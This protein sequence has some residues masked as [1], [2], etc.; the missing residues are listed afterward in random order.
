MVLDKI[1]I[2]SSLILQLFWRM[3]LNPGKVLQAYCIIMFIH[4]NRLSGQIKTFITY[5]PHTIHIDEDDEKTLLDFAKFCGK[6]DVSEITPLDV[7]RYE[8]SLRTVYTQYQCQIKLTLI[9]ALLR[10]FNFHRNMP[11]KK[12]GH[13]PRIDEIAKVK[14]LV[15]EGRTFREVSEATGINISQIHRWYHYQIPML[16]R[17]GST[18]PRKSR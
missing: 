7:L 5:R 8:Y 16:S 12:V 6:T 13:P 10:Y 9:R 15:D 4:K 18:E 11:K 17:G 1:Q 2:G 14:K 3:F